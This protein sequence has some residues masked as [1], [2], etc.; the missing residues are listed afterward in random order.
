MRLRGL[1]PWDGSVSTAIEGLWGKGA[2]AHTW[3]LL[4]LKFGLSHPHTPMGS[5]S[6][7]TLPT[8]PSVKRGHLPPPRLFQSSCAG[9]SRALPR[10]PP[11]AVAQS[12]HKRSMQPRISAGFRP[13]YHAGL[14]G[15]RLV[16]VP[17]DC[18]LF[19][20]ARKLAPSPLTARSPRSLGPFQP[21]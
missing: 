9:I 5:L 2:R 1:R 7:Y 19:C 20:A 18:M 4:N 11:P 17:R 10:C 21:G 12:T 15:F 6:I 13:M 8:T 16:R 14:S 3:V